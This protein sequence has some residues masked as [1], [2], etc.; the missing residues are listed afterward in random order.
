[1]VEIKEA[2]TRRQQK[3]FLEFPLKMYRDNP[4]FVPPI[5][6]DEKQIFSPKYHYYETA[7]AVYYNAY[8]DGKMVGRISGIL[9]Y[10]ANEK[11]DQKRVRFIRFD[12][13]DD[14]EVADALFHAVEEW[15]LNNGM[16]TVCGPLGFSDLEREGLLVEGFD[17]LST[18]EEQYNAEYYGRLVEN[19]GY[20][21]EVDWVE[22]KLYPAPE[23]A[24]GRLDRISDGLMKK[25]DLHEAEAKNINEV[26]KKYA[27]GIFRLIDESYDKLYGTVPLTEGAK[28]MLIDNFKLLIKL[29]Y[30]SLVLDEKEEPVCF[31][32][33]F[34]GI[35]EAL[36]K[37]GGRL[38]PA[39]LVRLLYT[40][41]HPKVMDLALV[42]VNPAWAKRGVGIIA[43][44]KM[45]RM[46]RR[47]APD[48]TETNL[49]LEDNYAIRNMWKRFQGVQHKR[50]RS[51]VKKL[52][53]E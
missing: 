34:P 29:P 16:D 7:K 40:I 20:A 23:N 32:L 27:D 50:R 28:K 4:Y 47:F 22:S 53:Q 41:R 46:L 8:R 15:A 30:L 18:F 21:K 31:G 45:D 35:G 10:A 39:C 14:Q 6:G 43:F 12:C 51:Y 13:I 42:G 38:T 48:H 33:G 1:M 11:W 17:Q 3:E 52:T 26:L 24:D 19:C 9:H 44:A 5:Y 25:Y 2:L 36:Q 37:S 49:N